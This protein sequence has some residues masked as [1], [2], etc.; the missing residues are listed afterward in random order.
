MDVL[1]SPSLLPQL[2]GKISLA[3]NSMKVKS[4]GD[5]CSYFLLSKRFE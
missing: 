3:M 5:Y 1:V 2:V 4:M